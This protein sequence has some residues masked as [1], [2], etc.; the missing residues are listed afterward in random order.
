MEQFY[1][2]CAGTLL[3]LFVAISPNAAF[4][5]ISPSDIPAGLDPGAILNAERLNA[6]QRGLFY[7]NLESMLKPPEP[8]IIDEEGILPKDL[9]LNGV[10]I[11]DEQIAEP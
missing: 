5:G 6:S 4:A 9:Q 11:P 7:G 10:I 3:F 8:V 2:A 1:S